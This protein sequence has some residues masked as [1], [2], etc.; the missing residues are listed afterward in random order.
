MES[1]PQQQHVQPIQVVAPSPQVIS[2]D[3]SRVEDKANKSSL[4]HGVIKKNMAAKPVKGVKI[5]SGGGTPA[6]PTRMSQRQIKRPKMDDELIDFES[7]SRGSASKKPKIIPSTSSNSTGG[8]S[9][10]TTLIQSNKSATG[11]KKVTKP[12]V[13]TV[14]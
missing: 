3:Q 8:S 11:Q 9:S 6:P 1:L 10:K 14:N 7:S 4:S 13:T 5:E 2:K 12:K